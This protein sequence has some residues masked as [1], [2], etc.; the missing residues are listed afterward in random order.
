MPGF[1]LTPELIKKASTDSYAT[2]DQV[3]QQLA[4][5][6][7]YVLELE[8]TWH[9][10]AQD[11]FQQLMNDW[12]VYARMMNDALRDIGQGLDGNYVN[13]IDTEQENIRN[14]QPVSGHPMPGRPGFD[15]PPSRF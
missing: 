14:L 7:N 10:V 6:R 4:V 15:L 2:A 11:T 8:Q 13:Y 3:W 9:G 12:D 5:L 1:R